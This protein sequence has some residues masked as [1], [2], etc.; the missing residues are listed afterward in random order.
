[1]STYLLCPLYIGP[2]S[3]STDFI[4]GVCCARDAVHD[5]M[6]E[7]LEKVKILVVGDV[8]PLESVPQRT[9]S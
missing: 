2:K 1:M 9:G 7:R 8:S 3:Y 5:Q 4:E 6:C